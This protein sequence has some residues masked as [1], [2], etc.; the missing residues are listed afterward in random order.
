[1]RNL[2]FPTDQMKTGRAEY[3]H[4]RTSLIDTSGLM[5]GPG[6]FGVSRLANAGKAMALTP[7]L[8]KE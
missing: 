1:M 5:G 6:S 3:R 4:R 2:L 7:I 8:H